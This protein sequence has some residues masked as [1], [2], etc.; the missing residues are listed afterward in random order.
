[1]TVFIIFNENSN[2]RSFKSSS[3]HLNFN[4]LRFNFNFFSPTFESERVIPN[5]K[6]FFFQSDRFLFQPERFFS[7]LGNVTSFPST[8]Q[9]NSNVRGVV[10]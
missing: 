10:F 3:D 6:R 2:F 4:E 8:S 1:M 5:L 9:L 7:N